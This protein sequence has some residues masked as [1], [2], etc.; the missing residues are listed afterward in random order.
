[1]TGANQDWITGVMGMP[2]PDWTC[3]LI[4]L[5]KQPAAL[6]TLKVEERN[7]EVLAEL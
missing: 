6:T 3:K 2:M 1:V 5:G 4:S 7:G